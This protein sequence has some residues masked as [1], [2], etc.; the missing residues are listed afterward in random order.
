MIHDQNLGVASGINIVDLGTIMS[1]CVGNCA[2]WSTIII[3]TLILVA[4]RY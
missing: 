4:K 2:I 1:R 3:A